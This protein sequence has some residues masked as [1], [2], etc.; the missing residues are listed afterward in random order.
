MPAFAD[1]AA[2]TFAEALSAVPAGSP[3]SGVTGRMLELF[4]A[5]T[6]SRVPA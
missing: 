3:V 5:G 1:D 2:D 6:L 4:T